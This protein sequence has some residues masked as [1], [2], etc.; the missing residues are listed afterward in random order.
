GPWPARVTSV[1]TD[2]LGEGARSSS[3]GLYLLAQLAVDRGRC[4]DVA[5]LADASTAVHDAGRAK[6]RPELLFLDAG[7][8][9]N[10]GHA[11]DA[12]ARFAAL[13][14]E[15]PDGA[16]AREAACYRFRALDVARGEDASLAPAYE[17]SLKSYLATYPHAEA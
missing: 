3:Y 12:A 5:P 16:R 4:A 2:K 13:G 1:V 6:H 15:F 8:R 11:R 7:C 17:E 9:L 10:A 14:E